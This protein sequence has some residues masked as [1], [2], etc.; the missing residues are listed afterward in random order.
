MKIIEHTEGRVRGP[1]LYRM[2]AA[3]YHA[4]PSPEPSLS[5]SIAKL[6]VSH[7]EEHAHAAHPRLGAQPGADEADATRPRE[8]GTA[9]HKLILGQGSDL[10]VIDADDYRTAA[11]KAERAAAYA[12]GHCPIL[13]PDSAK[14]EAMADQVA[15]RLGEIEGCGAFA[16]APAEVV[17]IAR[18]RSG[19]WLR[20]MMDKVELGSHHA[21]IWDVKTGDQSAAPQGLGR[22][23][24]SMGMEVQSALYVRALETLMPQLAGRITFRWIFVENDFPHP[25]CVAEADGATMHVGARK[26]SAAIHRW[27]AA[28]AS[29]VW[30]SYPARIIRAEYPEWAAKRWAER[31]ELD[32]ALAGVGYDI[33]QSPHR[34]LDWENAA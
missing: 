13:R 12:A 18:D 26:V 29:G 9:A 10:V 33:G 24:E 20:I 22:R 15:E 7:S 16:S 31:E 8:I 11:A 4:D 21:I 14:A 28:R 2:P 19:T 34:P 5:S 25:L 6:L 23:I 32:P 1:G 30:P 17:A 3:L 27:N